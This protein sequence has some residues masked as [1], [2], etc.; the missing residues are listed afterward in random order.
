MLRM[1]ST[2][3]FYFD[4]LWVV[5]SL[6]IMCGC[7]PLSLG[8]CSMA[9]YWIYFI[10]CSVEDFG[11]CFGSFQSIVLLFSVLSVEICLTD[12]FSYILSSYE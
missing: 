2:P 8:L 4:P 10:L 12:W 7:H 6:V 1:I 9:G 5:V 3:L 11:L